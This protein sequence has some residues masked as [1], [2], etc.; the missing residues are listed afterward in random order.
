MSFLKN[1]FWG[2]AGAA[3]YAAATEGKTKSNSGVS[4]EL[5]PPDVEEQFE[6]S[7]NESLRLYAMGNQRDGFDRWLRNGGIKPHEKD[8]ANALWKI[9]RKRYG[10]Y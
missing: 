2:A 10:R 3:V 6:E 7:V 1:I 4:K 9:Y 8:K 5:P